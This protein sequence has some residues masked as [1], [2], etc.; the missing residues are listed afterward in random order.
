MLKPSLFEQLKLLG[1]GICARWAVMTGF[2]VWTLPNREKIDGL[3]RAVCADV[4]EN[5][6][7]RFLR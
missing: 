2:S 6:I 4:P 5:A 1:S 3:K 7:P